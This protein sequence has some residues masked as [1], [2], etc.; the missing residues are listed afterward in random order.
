MNIASSIPCKYWQISGAKAVFSKKEML[1]KGKYE[2]RNSS[3]E[4]KPSFDS[5]V[6]IRGPK[7][8]KS[9]QKLRI[10]FQDPELGS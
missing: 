2:K 4:A 8:C 5:E 6:T 7:I 10:S 1:F 9:V 3:G